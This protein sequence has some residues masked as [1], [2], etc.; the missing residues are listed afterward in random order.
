MMNVLKP[1]SLVLALRMMQISIPLVFW[2]IFF[3]IE[4]DFLQAHIILKNQ[5][6]RG[7]L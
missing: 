7:P 3:H 2:N 6:I 1:T 4:N 5:K